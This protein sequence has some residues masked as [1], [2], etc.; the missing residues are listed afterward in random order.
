MHTMLA[1][2]TFHIA[3]KTCACR[4]CKKIRVRTFQKFQKRIGTFTMDILFI[5]LNKFFFCVHTFYLFKKP[6]NMRSFPVKYRWAICEQHQDPHAQRVFN[7]TI[8]H[9]ISLISSVGKINVLR[10]FYNNE[11]H[12]RIQVLTFQYQMCI[13]ASTLKNK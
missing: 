12:I 3:M 7:T 5:D 13:V 4:G 9:P 11:L 8:Q 1:K 6:K 2:T 10:H